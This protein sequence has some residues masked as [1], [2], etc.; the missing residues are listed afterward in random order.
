MILLDFKDFEAV[1]FKVSCP[2]EQINQG[3]DPKGVCFVPTE[4]PVKTSKV[5]EL[6]ASLGFV[7]IKHLNLRMLR[8]DTH[9]FD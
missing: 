8:E 6:A 3:Q 2:L 7:G 9:D 1:M 4:L 5:L